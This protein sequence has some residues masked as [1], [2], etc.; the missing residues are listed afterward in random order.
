[1]CVCV[2]ASVLRDDVLHLRILCHLLACTMFLL[3]AWSPSS[4]VLDR[5]CHL[6]WWVQCRRAA[7]FFCYIQVKPCLV[8]LS[9]SCFQQSNFFRH[10][11][12]I[13][14]F[15]RILC[16]CKQDGK[17]VVL[18]SYIL[19]TYPNLGHISVVPGHKLTNDLP[20][21]LFSSYTL[22]HQFSFSLFSLHKP[23]GLVQDVGILGTFQQS[24][25]YYWHRL[26]I[27]PCM[28][29]RFFF[30]ECFSFLFEIK[31][32]NNKRPDI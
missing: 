7:M 18:R 1:M 9:T 24:W 19:T 28:S 25:Y 21:I 29:N 4:S 15:T 22:L 16:L 3:L 6:S 26:F 12:F 30:T 32:T 23:F 17:Y 11:L 8:S 2:C 27:I 5:W 20:K 31:T 10:F 14:Y 13:N